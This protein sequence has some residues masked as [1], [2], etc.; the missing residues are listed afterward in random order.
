MNTK[1]LAIGELIAL[2]FSKSAA[3]R[4]MMMVEHGYTVNSIFLEKNGEKRRVYLSGSVDN[5]YS[6]EKNINVRAKM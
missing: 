3:K 1:Q 5:G 6:N 2:G 4:V